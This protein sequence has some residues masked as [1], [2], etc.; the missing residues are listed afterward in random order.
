MRPAPPPLTHPPDPEQGKAERLLAL[1][2]RLG[3][4]RPRDLAPYGIQPE[5]LR[6][7]CERGRLRK[8]GRGSY[9]VAGT[10]VDPR[11]KLAVVARAVP[12]AVIGLESALAVH[13]LGRAPA[14]VDLVIESRA[15]T[16][17]LDT[18]RIRVW[19]LS[20]EAFSEGVDA[21]A[22]GPVPV[23]VYGLEKTLA[24]LFRFR[25][26]IGPHVAVDALRSALRSGRVDR[27]RLIACARLNR[28]ERVLRP[29]LEAL[30]PAA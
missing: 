10:R 15:A 12:H 23:P 5:Y 8:V 25:N 19:R 3:V 17:R 26:K 4:V 30:A 29:F 7:L 2:A 6:R 16:P 1:V 22:I 9:V 18:P 20:G 24:D 28:V 27:D 14:A 11:L 21:I 13:G